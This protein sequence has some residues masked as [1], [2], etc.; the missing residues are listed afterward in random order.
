MLILRHAQTSPGTGGIGLQ[1]V[2]LG[3]VI[4][5]L[6]SRNAS[7]QNSSGEVPSRIDGTSVRDEN[8]QLS[9]DRRF[10]RVESSFW[11]AFGLR[12]SKNGRAVGPNILSVV[13]DDAVSGS[14]DARRHAHHARIFQGA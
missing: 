12:F 4:C 11:G 13:P 5:L 1:Y 3:V 2:L 6:S 7:A 8:T 9:V 14:K 10:L